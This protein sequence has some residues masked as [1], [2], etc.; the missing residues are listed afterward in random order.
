MFGGLDAFVNSG[1]ME[2]LQSDILLYG[3]FDQLRAVAVL[4]PR[5][6]VKLVELGLSRSETHADTCLSFGHVGSLTYFTVI[7]DKAFI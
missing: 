1:E 5:Q 2:M 3:F 6:R 7:H 4:L